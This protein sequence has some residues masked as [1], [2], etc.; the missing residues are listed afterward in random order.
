MKVVLSWGDIRP[1][2]PH[3]NRQPNMLQQLNY[4]PHHNPQTTHIVFT[5]KHTNPLINFAE[6]DPRASSFVGSLLND[7]LQKMVEFTTE[8][9]L[10]ETHLVETPKTNA[11]LHHP[12][13]VMTS[14]H[15]P[16]SR[17]GKPS[18]NER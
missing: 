6:S 7:N 12:T 5:W 8:N 3:N 9:G 14:S 2:S 18:G 4:P 17:K 13:A 15:C 11:F 1:Y 10:V 16:T